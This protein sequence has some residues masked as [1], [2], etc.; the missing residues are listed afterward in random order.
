MPERLLFSIAKFNKKERK[1][2]FSFR[3]SQTKTFRANRVERKAMSVT[4]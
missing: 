4:F 2:S 1:K 3:E